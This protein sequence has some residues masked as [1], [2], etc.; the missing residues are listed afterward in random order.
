MRKPREIIDGYS[1]H[2]TARIN[3]QEYLFSSNKM[4]EMF[5]NVVVRAKQKF[6]FLLKNFC[7]M[8]N[9]IHF[10]IKPLKGENLSKIMQWIL[11]VFAQKFNRYFRLKG[12]VWYDRFKS[13]VIVTL[14]QW[15]NT[16][17]YITNN[18]V[19]AGLVKKA[20]EYEYSGIT[21]ML[22]GIPG[23]VDK[24]PDK[25]FLFLLNRINN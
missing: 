2:V 23:V 13:K 20:A 17:I 25:T 19:E 18:P 15:I 10:I 8:G 4:K 3:R 1:Y 22:K 7:I 9:H 5:I 11:S 21:H 12:H 16:F 24:P 6:N 14:K